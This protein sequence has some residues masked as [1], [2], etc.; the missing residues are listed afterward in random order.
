MTQSAKRLTLDFS[1]G[2][3]PKAVGSSPTSGSVMTVWGLFGI[4][5]LFLSAPPLL[6]HALSLSK[7]TFKKTTI[8]LIEKTPKRLLIWF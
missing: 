3:D 7:E 5:S 1:L 6:A 8:H 4:L 2:H